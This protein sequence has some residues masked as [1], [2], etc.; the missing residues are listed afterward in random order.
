MKGRRAKADCAPLAEVAVDAW[1]LRLELPAAAEE[2][3]V[4][5]DAMQ[6][7][8]AAGGAQSREQVGWDVVVLRDDVPGRYEAV[9]PLDLEH[10]V[11]VGE[12]G[13][14]LD[15]VREDERKAAAVGPEVQHRYGLSATARELRRDPP[16]LLRHERRLHLPAPPRAS[17]LASGGR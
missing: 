14:S 1:Q 3:A 7:D 17:S 10:P 2:A 9:A 15:V 13:G 12:S 5:G 6:A 4:V 11:D 16:P 8:L